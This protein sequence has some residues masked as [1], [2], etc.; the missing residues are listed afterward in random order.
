M[1]TMASPEAL[2]TAG[3]H[4]HVAAMQIQISVITDNI[5]KCSA[6]TYV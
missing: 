3:G 4:F 2:I 6:S 5:S 1:T